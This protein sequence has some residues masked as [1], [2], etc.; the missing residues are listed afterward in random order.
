MLFIIVKHCGTVSVDD[1]RK[2][3]DV[4]QCLDQVGKKRTIRHQVYGY[5]ADI[6][7]K[8]PHAEIF[9]TPL[10][11]RMHSVYGQIKSVSCESLFL[12]SGGDIPV[13]WVDVKIE[14]GE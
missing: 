9:D 10:K 3:E 8:C 11:K 5:V 13:G 1:I 12:R 6:C 7:K 14:I 2:K 4:T